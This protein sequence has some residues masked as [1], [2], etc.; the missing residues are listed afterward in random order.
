MSKRLVLPAVAVLF[1]WAGLGRAGSFFGPTAYGAAYYREYPQRT[2]LGR[3]GI[4][5]PFPRPAPCASLAVPPAAPVPGTPPSS[6]ALE[7]LPLPVPQSSVPG[8]QQ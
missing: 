8:P 3:C 6:A 4:P 1:T 2:R 7:Q 5:W